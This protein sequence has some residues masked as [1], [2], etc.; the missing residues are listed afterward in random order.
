[1]LTKSLISL[2]ANQAIKRL[3]VQFNNN[4]DTTGEDH[5]QHEANYDE[6]AN[7]PCPNL[8]LIPSVPEAGV[9]SYTTRTTQRK[10]LKNHLAECP[11]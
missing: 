8:C 1:M 9:A 5:G 2:A 3:R 11:I 6:N 7:I 10:D 4:P